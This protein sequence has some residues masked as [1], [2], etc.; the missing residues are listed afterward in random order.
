MLADVHIEQAE[1]DRMIGKEQGTDAARKGAETLP[2][3]GGTRTDTLLLM[4]M[5]IVILLMIAN[6]GLFL[7]MNQLQRQVLTALEPARFVNPPAEGLDKGTPAPAFSLSDTKGGQVSLADLA[8]QQ[9]LLVFSSISCPGCIKLFPELKT[10]S[11]QSQEV[12]VVM[13]SRASEE[14]N[15]QLV[16]EQGFAFVVLNWQDA[17]AQDYQVPGTPFAYLIDEQGIIVNKGFVAAL[18]QLEELVEARD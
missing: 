10:F 9:T 16:E 7:R 2:P 15:V 3:A 6:I 11:E 8:G 17:V 12:R 4:L 1:G 13:V 14:E 18:E 5:G